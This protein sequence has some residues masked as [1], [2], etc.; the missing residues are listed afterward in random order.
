MDGLRTMT[1]GSP[2]EKLKFLFDVYDMDGTSIRPTI[3]SVTSDK[4][5]SH[6]WFG[7]WSSSDQYQ[8]STQSSA[9]L[10]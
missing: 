8:T 4:A 7:W 1:K 2:K 3:N 10:V 9:D 5:S 6:N